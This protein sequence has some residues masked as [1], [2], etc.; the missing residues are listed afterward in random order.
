ME[1]AR[2]EGMPMAADASSSR[3]ARAASQMAGIGE[4]FQRMQGVQGV[5]L[6]AKRSRPAKERRAM[7]LSARPEPSRRTGRTANGWRSASSGRDRFLRIAPGPPGSASA[8]PS[9]ASAGS[10]Q[11]DG[12][13]LLPL[14]AV[15]SWGVVGGEPSRGGRKRTAPDGSRTFAKVLSSGTASGGRGGF[16][17]GNSSREFAGGGMAARCFFRKA[18]C[19]PSEWPPAPSAW[20]RASPALAMGVARLLACAWSCLAIA[21]G[22]KNASAGTAALTKEGAFG[23]TRTAKAARSPPRRRGKPWGRTLVR[24]FQLSRRVPAPAR[25]SSCRRGPGSGRPQGN[26]RPPLAA[27]QRGP[28]KAVRPGAGAGARRLEREGHAA[29]DRLVALHEVAGREAV[30]LRAHALDGEAG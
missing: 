18:T 19:A 21:S 5:R 17:S 15:S 12:T 2:A 10:R 23:R 4:A 24:S 9:G 13:L 16:G 22:K 29:E 27:R 1:D 25:Q 14:C 30:L 6:A 20:P 28:G 7:R 26:G 3:L 8:L 11:Q